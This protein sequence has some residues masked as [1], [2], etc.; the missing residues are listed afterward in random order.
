[1]KNRILRFVALACA[2]PL[3]FAAPAL[4]AQAPKPVRTRA[5]LVQGTVQDDITVYKGIP[6]GAPPVGDLRWRPPQPAAPWKGVKETNTFAPACMQ[7]P[8]VM[9]A[10]GLELIPVSEDCLYL[11][12]WTP[13]KSPKD[14]LAVMV[15]IYGGGFTIGGTSLSQYDGM[16]LAKKGVVYVSIAYRLGLFGFFAH[17]ELTAEQGGTR[18]TM[19]CSIRSPA[20]SGYNAISRDSAAILIA[21]PFSANP[22]AEFPSACWP[23][24]R[25]PR[26]SSKARSRRAEAT[27]LPLAA[28]AKAAKTWSRLPPP[29]KAAPLCFQSSM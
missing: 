13:A 6:F 28:A 1:M 5:G 24:R 27:S 12:V 20:S 14:K 25:W 17:P 11:N 22:R 4:L 26:A 7:T 16:N 23:P 3:A 21:S 10:L 18:A 2:A 19:A 9:P 8:I 29:S 15:W